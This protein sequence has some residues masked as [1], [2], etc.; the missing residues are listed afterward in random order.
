MKLIL[1]FICQCMLQCLSHHF[2]TLV[3]SHIAESMINSS[4]EDILWSQNQQAVPLVVGHSQVRVRPSLLRLM[5]QA[6][7]IT[8][9]FML[10]NL[11]T[12]GICPVTQIPEVL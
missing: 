8:P 5:H 6:V 11:H 2:V 1:K 9:F 12:V 7:S 10:P 4:T 3:H